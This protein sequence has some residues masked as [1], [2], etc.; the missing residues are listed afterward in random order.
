MPSDY[1]FKKKRGG[2]D[3]PHFLPLIKTFGEVLTLGSNLRR[4]SAPAG[5]GKQL[6]GAREGRGKGRLRL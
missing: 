2:G 5:R 1:L 6:R 4:C 3:P